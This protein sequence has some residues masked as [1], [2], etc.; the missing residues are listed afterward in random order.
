MIRR[1]CHHAKQIKIPGNKRYLILTYQGEF[2]KVH[3][4]LA[5]MPDETINEPQAMKNLIK[6]LK[7][8]VA[9]F[10]KEKE[11]AKEERRDN[12]MEGWQNFSKKKKKRKV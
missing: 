10:K 2:D 5:L 4:P 1:R 6:S 7:Q 12:R 9:N 8:E 3:Y 11:W